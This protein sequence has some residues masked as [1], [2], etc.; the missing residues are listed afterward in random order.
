MLRAC[1][2]TSTPL[3]SEE[4]VPPE[5]APLGELQRLSVKVLE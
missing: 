3:A 5:A 1:R 4:G 2:C